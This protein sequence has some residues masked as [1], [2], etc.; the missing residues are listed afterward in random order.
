MKDRP[1]RLKRAANG[2]KNPESAHLHI[3]FSA[4][5]KIPAVSSRFLKKIFTN[6]FAA[7]F[8]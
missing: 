5:V 1:F 3:H 8:A 6:F 4:P 7:A 2:P